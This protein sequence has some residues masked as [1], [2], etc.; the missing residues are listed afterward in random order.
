MKE[1]PLTKHMPRVITVIREKLIKA[2]M[3]WKIVRPLFIL[4]SSN[5]KDSDKLLQLQYLNH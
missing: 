3:F 1:V 5:T 2:T 4:Q